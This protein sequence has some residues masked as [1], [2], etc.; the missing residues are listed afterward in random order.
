MGLNGEI[1]V[2]D[3]LRC[4]VAVFDK[5]GVY[6]RDIGSTGRKVNIVSFDQLLLAS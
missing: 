3:S 1:L 4:A 2:V 6:I 5:N